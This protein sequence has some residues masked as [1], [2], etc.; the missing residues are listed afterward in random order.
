MNG[1]ANGVEQIVGLGDTKILDSN[2][3]HT[4]DFSDTLLIGIAEVNAAGGN[5]VIATS[6]LSAGTYRGGSGNDKFHTGE[7][8]VTLLY[9]GTGNGYDSFLTNGTGTARA[10]VETAESIVGLNSYNNGIDQFIG[11]GDSILRDSNSS[12]TLNFSSTILDG[13]FEIDAAGGNDTII[14]SNVSAAIYRGNSGNDTI[15]FTQ[16]PSS[17]PNIE[18]GI[19][20]FKS[21]ADL[22]DFTDTDL[23]FDD[24]AQVG[25][26]IVAEVDEG[27]SLRLI[28][29][30][31]SNIE[32]EDF[33]FSEIS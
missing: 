23:L 8:D 17:Q 15:Q 7:Q 28:D 27:T 2:S 22:L 32:E 16:R 10:L 14:V 20:D 4:L 31:L 13:I 25:N 24:L 3:S 6:N 33:L 5:D 18:V 26:D 9:S 12:H 21:G 19:A 30:L 1:Y 11:V 29:T